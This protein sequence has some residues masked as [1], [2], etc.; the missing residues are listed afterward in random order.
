MSSVIKGITQKKSRKV[1]GEKIYNVEPIRDPLKLDEMKRYLLEHNSQRDWFLFYLGINTGLRVNDLLNLKYKD[2]L[3]SHIIIREEKTN[4]VKQF[5]I[6]SAIRRAFLELANGKNENEWIFKQ[7]KGRGHISRQ[8]AHKML[9]EAGKACGMDF[10]GTHSMRKSF[11]YHYYKRTKDIAK[12]QYIF[13]HSAPSVTLRYIGITQEEVDV[14]LN[15][16]EL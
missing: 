10:V 8:F 13:N 14:S 16:F 5:P 6:N 15:D 12:L 9:K 11:G 1:A 4:K 7:A 2:L 3:G